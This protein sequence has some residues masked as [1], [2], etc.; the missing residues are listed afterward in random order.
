MTGPSL[1]YGNVTA[2]LALFVALGGTATAAKTMIDGRDIKPNTISSRQIKDH[3]LRLV[4]LRPAD[5]KSLSH[6]GAA[7]Q[8]GKAGPAGPAGPQGPTGS[9][10][11]SGLAGTDAAS[12]WA[13]VDIGGGLGNNRGALGSSRD[14]DGQYTV[15][16]SRVVTGCAFSITPVSGGGG[17]G[18]DVTS[19]GVNANQLTIQ[20]R[21]YT[22]STV[23]RTLHVVAFC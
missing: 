18:V 5:R 8:E 21:D 22:N 15:L 19:V 13:I 3:S 10:G 16:W 1:T 6:P 4:D 12:L 17:Q 23:N 7:G 20:I 14:A 11:P 2:T 9:Q